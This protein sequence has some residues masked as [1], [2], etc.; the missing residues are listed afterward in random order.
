MVPPTNVGVGVEDPIVN[1]KA[2]GLGC[3]RDN[4]TFLRGAAPRDCNFS[5]D[6]V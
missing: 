2:L 3:D 6:H 1:R 5:S 4:F